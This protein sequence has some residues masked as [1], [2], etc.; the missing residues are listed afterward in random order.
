M[1]ILY[2]SFFLG[3]CSPIHCRLTVAIA[4]VLC[5]LMSCAAGFGICFIY[6][7]KGSEI[8]SVLPVLMLGIGVDD[9]F[10]VCNAIDQVPLNLPTSE[11]IKRGMQHAGPSITITSLTDCM[12]FFIGSTNSMLAIKSFCIF[13]GVTVIMLYLSVIT[14]FLSVVVWDTR[15]VE[16]KGKECCGMCCCKED[17]VLFCSG[18]FLTPN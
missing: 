13:C 6:D 11:R 14:I 17:S 7:W 10:V 5:V 12:A 3:S 2:C 1:I 4:G 9:M 16:R 8:I 18:L 15:R